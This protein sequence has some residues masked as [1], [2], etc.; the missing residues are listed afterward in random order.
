MAVAI[1]AGEDG[2][3][4]SASSSQHVEIVQHGGRT[5]IVHHEPADDREGADDGR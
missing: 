3:V 4:T 2:A 1:N 5:T